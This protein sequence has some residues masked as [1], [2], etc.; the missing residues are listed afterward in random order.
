[1]RKINQLFLA[2]LVCLSFTNYSNAQSGDWVWLKGEKFGESLGSYGTIGVSSPANEPPSRYQAAYWKDLNGNFWMFGGNP[3]YN[4]LWKYNPITNEW[5]WIKGPKLSTA[6]SGVFGTMGVPSALN[7]PPALGFGANC[8]TDATGDLWLFAG[9]NLGGGPNSDVLWRYNIATNEWTWMKGNSGT[10]LSANYGPKGV[11]GSAYTPGSRDEC[12]SAWVYAGKLWLFGG[13]GYGMIPG[14]KND[15]WSYDIGTN[16]WAWESGSTLS[17]DMGSY[18]VKGVASASNVPPSR[19][20]YTRWQD[21]NNNFYLFGGGNIFSFGFRNDV[22]QYNTKTKMWTWIGGTDDIED[23]GTI[24]SYCLPD[25]NA[26]PASRYENQSAQSNSVCTKAFWTFGG[27]NFSGSLFNDLWLFN[28]ENFEW[29]KVKGGVGDPPPFS[30]GTKGVSSPANLIPGK[31]GSCL[32]TD[33]NGVL[34]VFGGYGNTG[35]GLEFMNDLWK[36]IPDT[37]CFKT[38]LVG[39]VE[40]NPPTDTVICAGDTV[41]MFI[42]LNCTIDVS[43]S[44]GFNINKTAGFIEFFSATTTKYTVIATSLNP[45]DPCFKNDTISFTITGYP[46]PKADFNINPLKA[47]IDNPVFNF[48]NQSKNAARYEWYYEGV[49]IS[50]DLDL[51]Y[52]FSK[53]GKYCI[54]LVAINKCG[55]RD[56]VTKCCYVVDN[57]KLPTTLDSAICPGDTLFFKLPLGVGFDITPSS[58]FELD[59]ARHLVKFYPA[60][61][62]RYSIITKIFGDPDFVGDTS[63]VNIALEV[64]PKADFVIN[65]FIA[66]IDKPDFDFENRSANAVRYQWYY[67]GEL[68][69]T[70]KNTKKSFTDTGNYCVKLI[71][72]NNCDQKDSVIQCCRVYKKGMLLVPN[73][74][75][76]NGDGLNDGFKALLSGSYQRFKML[77]VNRYGQEVFSSDNPNE[78]WDGKFKSQDLD[79]GVYYYLITITFDYPDAK[80]EIYKGD[81]SLLR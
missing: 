9:A 67:N 25:V 53:M 79:L 10:T 23:T 48:S 45:N 40:L 46:R 21:A 26:I 14:C 2:I 47:K 16:N 65:P 49:L 66:S 61:N 22:W 80:E 7:S 52:T 69:S 36:F 4:D 34:Y 77:I 6:L 51:T 8:W 5:T 63:Y 81:V 31:L 29:T 24:T 39:G 76:P 68:I 72:I 41:K 60:V 12:K 43:P 15:L 35:I 58:G 18:G 33:K 59:T 70:N 54:T 55:H 44:S 71:A 74:F 57:L 1:M 19:F 13:Q 78:A 17:D 62:T 42:P 3:N 38:G 75:T 28:T 50:T 20:S 11:A 27:S 32:W 30:Y 37:S 64:A 56:S 73:A